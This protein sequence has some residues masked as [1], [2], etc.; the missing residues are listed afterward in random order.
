MILYTSSILVPCLMCVVSKGFFPPFGKLYLY[1]GNCFFWCV[2][3]F[4]LY[5]T[6][7]V[8]SSIISE[9]YIQ[10]PMVLFWEQLLPSVRLPHV[11]H[12]SHVPHCSQI[13]TCPENNMAASLWGT[14][15]ESQLPVPT[16]HFCPH[17][18]TL[19]KWLQPF[20]YP[21]C[22]QPWFHQLGFFPAPY[23]YGICVQEGTV[24]S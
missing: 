15:G 10:C 3:A 13:I 1:S 22:I 20:L 11:Q 24:P 8:D 2:E 17:L 4:Q 21:R 19:Q 7:F 14:L 5:I 6:L 18:H 23:S 16:L 12:N 9:I